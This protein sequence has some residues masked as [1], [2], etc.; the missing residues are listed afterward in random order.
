MLPRNVVAALI[1]SAGGADAATSSAST[2]PLSFSPKIGPLVGTGNKPLE[3]VDEATD[4]SN[5]NRDMGD[6]TGRRE[7]SVSPDGETS[8]LPPGGGKASQRTTR[9]KERRL[10]A[11]RKAFEKVKPADGT[12]TRLTDEELRD[13]T[14][15]ANADSKAG[16]KDLHKHQWLR[17]AAWYNVGGGGDGSY[18]PYDLKTMVS[19]GAEYDGWA[20][21]YRMLGGVIDCDKE[22][23]DSEG[24]CA[25]WMMWAAYVNPNYQGGGYD[26]YYG[27][28]AVSVLDCHDPNTEWQLLG[29]YRQEFYQFYEQISKHLW[30]I[31]E[32]EYIVALAGLAYM[33]DVDCFEVDNGYYAGPEPLQGGKMQ[34]SLYSD[35]DCLYPQEDTGYT[36]D[37]M[38]MQSDVELG[39]QHSGDNG[40]NGGDDDYVDN[41]EQ[42]W[43]DAQEYTFT[44]FNEVYDDFLYCTPCND[45]PTY[46]DGYFIGDDGTDEDDIINQCWK[47]FSH[48]THNCEADCIAQGDA[49]GTITQITYGDT[50]F[51]QALDMSG[52][53]GGGTNGGATSKSA[54]M[55][56]LKANLFVT[57]AGIVFVATFLAFAVARGSGQ[58]RRRRRHR[59]SRSKRL[60]DDDHGAEQVRSSRSASRS[61]RSK[62]RSR[63]EGGESRRSKSRGEGERDH[64]R[65]SSRRKSRSGRESSRRP[66]DDF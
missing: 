45:Y 18:S 44:M 29:V 2:T 4:R 9:L 50:T 26:E 43:Y 27:D 7:A 42:Y 36:Y 56:R 38:G 16:G 40:D 23:D 10:Q 52:W 14:D 21:A 22:R 1:A 3:A 25:R 33:T 30:A 63:R 53:S 48:D 12:L 11:Y 57:F 47:F 46:Q 15:K 59:S 24:G 58:R 28:E 39:S 31:D 60:L 49:Q 5:R 65:S 20:Q 66:L 32:Y 37:D 51:G 55:E 8:F 34:M 17:R 61:R 62:S 13:A 35:E 64:R 6:A 41:A 19:P 54:R